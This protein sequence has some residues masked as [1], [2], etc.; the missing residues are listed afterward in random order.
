MVKKKKIQTKTCFVIIPS[1]TQVMTHSVTFQVMSVKSIRAQ[2]SEFRGGMLRF[3]QY[4][5][6]SGSILIHTLL[7]CWSIQLKVLEIV[8]EVQ[9]FVFG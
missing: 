1:A 8:I 2:R 3:S 7:V 5:R 9:L 4:L 6:Q